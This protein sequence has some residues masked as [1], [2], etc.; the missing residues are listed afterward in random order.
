MMLIKRRRVQ[1]W[2]WIEVF[3]CDANN[4]ESL[5]FCMTRADMG[6]HRYTRSCSLLARSIFFK[7]NQTEK[8]IWGKNIKKKPCLS[9]SHAESGVTDRGTSSHYRIEPPL[10]SRRRGSPA[11]LCPHTSWSAA[12]SRSHTSC[13][14]DS[15]GS[16]C[17]SYL[18]LKQQ[19]STTGRD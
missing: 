13:C 17:P 16:S 3:A 7:C 8:N 11:R 12:A 2:N 9:L 18:H 5:Q 4:W 6:T 10:P 1:F 14:R 15:S 19:Q